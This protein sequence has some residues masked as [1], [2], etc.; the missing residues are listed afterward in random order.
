[1]KHRSFVT[2]T[3]TLI[4]TG[5]MLIALT[6]AGT[7]CRA[8]RIDGTDGDLQEVGRM[9]DA[10]R[11]PSEKLR[12]LLIGN[13]FTYCNDL[14]QSNG[15]FARIAKNA[16]YEGVR[17]NS[18]YSGG[19]HL[20]QFLDSSDIFGKQVLGALGSERKYDIVVIQEQ[21]ATPIADPEEFYD[22]CRRFKERVDK[23][24]GELWLYATWGYKDGCPDLPAF[25]SSSA[26]MEMKLRS[27]YAS[28]AA[29]LGIG[30]VCAGAAFTE[31]TAKNPSIDLYDTDLKHPSPE[32]SYLVAWTMFGTIF[33]VDPATLSYY[34]TL[35]GS[36]A[37][38][39]RAV[40]SSIVT[41]GVRVK[42]RIE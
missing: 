5:I 8:R 22:S 36:D 40:A 9:I 42:R 1:M 21:S 20:R 17:V 29:E 24:G 34:G 18:I 33:G 16:G 4:I 35:S 27:A 39:L 37:S 30:V 7:G 32:G 31:S 25:G 13:S 28:I 15:I 23:N 3:I 11:D 26:D 2:K 14:N 6:A 38:K 41:E 10:P 12:V 19:Y